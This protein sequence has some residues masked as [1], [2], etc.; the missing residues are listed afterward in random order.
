M[1]SFFSLERQDFNIRVKTQGDDLRNK[2]RDHTLCINQTGYHCML[3]SF[4][5]LFDLFYKLW[6]LCQPNNALEITAFCKGDVSFFLCCQRDFWLYPC[7]QLRVLGYVQSSY[8]D[9]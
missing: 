9:H 3:F 4:C 7:D 5:L 2:L 1:Q 8:G 6:A